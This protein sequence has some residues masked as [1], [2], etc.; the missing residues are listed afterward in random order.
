MKI[1]WGK[2]LEEVKDWAVWIGIAIILSFV[3]GNLLNL[4]LGNTTPLVAVMSG[5]MVHDSTT[6]TVHYGYLIGMGFS[7]SEILGFPLSSGFSKG[8]VLV[9]KGEK[10]GALKVGDVVVFNAPGARYPIIHRIIGIQ[11]DSTGAS[12]YR[13]KGDHNSAPDS[14]LT[15]H[16]NVQGKAIFKVP[17][18]GYVKVVP[19]EICTSL[20]L[21]AGLFGG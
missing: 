6:E 14:W 7:R 16:K 21:C 13:T 8:D 15:P 20:G 2:I 4:A 10:D 5:S 17:V 19:L 3:I 11:K 12:F 18:V 9:I 1:S